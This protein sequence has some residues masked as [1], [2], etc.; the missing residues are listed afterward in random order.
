MRFPHLTMAVLAASAFAT[1]AVLAADDLTESMPKV[2]DG[3]ETV[4][5]GITIDNRNDAK[6]RDYSL[7][8]EFAGK[9]GQYLGDE[10]VKV[11]G[12]QIDVSVNCKGPWVLMKLPAGSYHVSADVPDAGHKEM[13]VKIGGGQSVVVFSFPNAGGEISKPAELLPRVAS[14]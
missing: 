9:G 10:T 5:D 7:R 3:V 4:C 13:N 11:S 1:T 8:L 6:W 2:I 12:H 14:R